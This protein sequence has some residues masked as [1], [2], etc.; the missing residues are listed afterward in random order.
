MSFNKKKKI[1]L[2]KTKKGGA[3]QKSLNNLVKTL[4]KEG[5][6]N[7]IKIMIDA[8]KEAAIK[9]IQKKEEEFKKILFKE[10]V[11]PLNQQI[12]A[13]KKAIRELDAKNKEL[14]AEN[15]QLKETLHLEETIELSQNNRSILNI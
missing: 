6:N 3:N 7:S 10:H 2:K 13:L 11:F 8:L 4:K 14:Y 9:E 5:T 12:F 15:K 1:Y